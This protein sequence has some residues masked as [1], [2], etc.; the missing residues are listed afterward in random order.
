[1][2]QGQLWTEH[3]VSL[4]LCVPHRNPQQRMRGPRGLPEGQAWLQP[5]DF[6][7]YFTAPGARHLLTLKPVTGRGKAGA[8]SH[9]ATAHTE[10]TRK[11][12]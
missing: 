12:W 7:I 1:M 2:G 9:A 4:S 6:T 3:L 11:I 5:N 8:H 10:V